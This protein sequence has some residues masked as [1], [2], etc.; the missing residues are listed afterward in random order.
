METNEPRLIYGDCLSLLENAKDDCN[1]CC[2]FFIKN[3]MDAPS[4]AFCFLFPQEIV[5]DIYDN[6]LAIQQHRYRSF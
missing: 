1:L 6:L 3:N 2:N 5:S 4:V